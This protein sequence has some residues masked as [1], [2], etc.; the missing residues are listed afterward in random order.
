MRNAASFAA[1][2]GASVTGGIPGSFWS[3][4]SL[5]SVGGGGGCGTAGA[6]SLPVISFQG[7][8]LLLFLQLCHFFLDVC[9]SFGRK[10][11]RFGGLRVT[12]R[13]QS[14]AEEKNDADEEVKTQGMQETDPASLEELVRQP[15][16]A[17]EEEAN[18][19]DEFGIPIQKGIEHVNNNVPERPPVID[20]GLTA[21]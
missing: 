10:I 7:Q 13:D 16:R 9:A 5:V 2:S 3:A 12:H 20:R 6:L 4:G 8:V 21:I 19:S 15:A 11:L 14:R 1:V 18:A 17:P